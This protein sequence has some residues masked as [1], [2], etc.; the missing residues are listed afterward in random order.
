M[1]A[2]VVGR[3]LAE[4]C[5][6]RHLR[7]HGGAAASD[8]AAVGEQDFAAVTRRLDRRIHAGAARSDHEHVG[9]DMHGLDHGVAL[10]AACCI[11]DM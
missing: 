3:L 1:M 11:S 9:L 6:D 2:P 10:W 8:Q 4:R 7:H 5:R